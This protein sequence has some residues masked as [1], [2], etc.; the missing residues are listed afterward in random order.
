MGSNSIQ[1]MKR[2]MWRRILVKSIVLAIWA[3]GMLAIILG[4]GQ[5][6]AGSTYLYM[7]F[8]IIAVWIVSTIRD[9]HRLRDEA[10]LL[11]ASIEEA[12]ERN[13]LITYKATRLA[14]VI[15]L[16]LFP[17][18]I[19]ALALNGMHETVNTL[20]YTVCVFLIVYVGSWFYVSRKS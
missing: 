5:E 6:L 14:V 9:V 15:T 4:G 16:C 18:A 13:V 17:I 7:L 10:A 20:G 11:K 8:A 19:C 1:N 12:D 3:V 2:R